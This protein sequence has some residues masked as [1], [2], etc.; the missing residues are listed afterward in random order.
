[1]YLEDLLPY[2]ENDPDL[3]VEDFI[4][5]ILE[6][7]KINGKLFYVAPEFSLNAVVAYNG[8]QGE[9]LSFDAYKNAYDEQPD[10]DSWR[11]IQSAHDAFVNAFPVIEN[12]VVLQKN[13]EYIVDTELLKGWLQ[14]CTVAPGLGI[15]NEMISACGRLPGIRAYTLQTSDITGWP[16]QRSNGYY[17]MPSG[18]CTAILANSQHKEAAW[19]FMRYF[20]LAYYNDTFDK[21]APDGFDMFPVIAEQFEKQLQKGLNDEDYPISEQD[22]QKLRNIVYSIQVPSFR[23]EGLKDILLPSADSY[24]SGQR[25][26]EDTIAQMESK[27]RLFLHEQD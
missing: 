20:F 11:F 7:M 23:H 14:F 12:D 6:A 4:P 9:N 18:Y 24:F 17:V 1:M 22:A 27:M 3:S 19:S 10:L 25:S 16:A 5:S 13:G 15:G 2:I 21:D 8:V 26:L